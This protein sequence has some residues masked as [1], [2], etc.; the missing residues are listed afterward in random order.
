MESILNW[1]K[2][3]IGRKDNSTCRFISKLN[4]PAEK[5]AT[6]GY[7]DCETTTQSND[8]E[9]IYTN[10]VHSEPIDG[11]NFFKSFDITCHFQRS[12]YLGVESSKEYFLNLTV[13]LITWQLKP[14][15]INI[16]FADCFIYW[17]IRD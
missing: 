5:L 15:W 3:Y 17:N 2:F 9:I 8:N 13:P 6:I 1:E 10:S 12:S 7:D 11:F 16:G 14:V 4:Q